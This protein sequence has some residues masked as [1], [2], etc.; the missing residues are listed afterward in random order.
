MAVIQSG[1][2]SNTC[3]KVEPKKIIQ[4]VSCFILPLVHNKR[5]GVYISALL[6]FQTSAAETDIP[7]ILTKRPILPPQTLL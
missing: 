5:P 7:L 3:M 1:I 2:Q 4:V 6:T